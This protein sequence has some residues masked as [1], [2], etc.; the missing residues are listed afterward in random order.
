MRTIGA[1]RPEIYRF[2]AGSGLNAHPKV[3]YLIMVY[4]V[5][6]YIPTVNNQE[7]KHETLLPEGIEK[8]P[9]RFAIAFRNKWVVDKSNLAVTYV[10]N[11]FGG[12]NQFKEY[13]LKKNKTDIELSE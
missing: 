8:V 7:Y 12:A 9:K 13:A 10:K 4:T 11:N 5:L 3:K 2:E 6:A 1:E